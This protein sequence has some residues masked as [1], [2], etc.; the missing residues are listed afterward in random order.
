MKKLFNVFYTDDEGKELSVKYCCVDK[1]QARRLFF[2]E[3]RKEEKIKKIIE[4]KV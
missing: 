3:F 1:S 4:V 2:S